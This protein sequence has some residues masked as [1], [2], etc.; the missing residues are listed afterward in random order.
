[1]DL[2]LCHIT[3]DFDALGAAIGLT[4]LMPG[5][6]VV[7]TGGAHPAVGDFLAFYRDEFPLIERRSV[8][9]QEIRNLAI[10]DTQKRDR[11]GKAAEWLDLPHLES[12]SVFDHHPQGNTDI[13][14]TMRQIEPVGATTTLI[15]E[16]IQAEGL[17]LTPA[18]ATVMALGIHVDTGSLTFPGTSQRDALALSW[19][20]GQKVQ[21][22]VVAQYV[23]PGLSL[24]LQELFK[25]ALERIDT[26]TVR[27]YQ[28]ASVLL[29]TEE[30]QPGLSTLAS[31]LRDIAETDALLLGAAYDG[32]KM[33]VI[34][35][36]QIPGVELNEL[37]QEFGGGGHP[38]AAALTLKAPYPA[39]TLAMLRDRLKHQV[40]RPLTARELMSSP[41]R[42]IRPETT[43]DEAQ[44]ILLRY[45]H[46]GL[47]V[48]DPEEGLVGM[49]SRRDIDLALHHG[50]S[51]APVKGYMA[52]QVKTVTPITLFPE[53]EALMVTY[54]IGRLPVL[55]EGKPV[56]IVTRTDVL[57]HL[58]RSQNHFDAG[59]SEEQSRI[60]L[61]LNLAKY[62][63]LPLWQILTQAA[64]AASARGWQLYVVGGSVRDLL[65]ARQYGN[66]SPELHDI[67]LV[68]D[69]FDLS[70]DTGAGVEL[71]K[72]LQ[73]I[74]PDSRLDVHGAFQTAALIW[75][76]HPTLGSL[77]LD[78]A[79]ARTE[80]YPYPAANPEVEASSI[81]QDLYRRD[82][83]INALA[84]R[85][86]PDR[87][88]EVLDFF[89]GAIDLKDRQI[90]VLH[91][92][93]LIEDP[94][95]IYRAVRFAVR[96]GFRIEAQ[97]EG[98]IRY[99]IESGVYQRSLSNNKKAPA[100]Q[101]RLRAELK[102]ILEAHYWEKAIKLLDSL[103]AL[104]CLHPSLKLNRKLWWQLHLLDRWLR[105][106]G[107]ETRRE[108]SK[109]T[110]F[111]ENL[112]HWLLRLEVLFLGIEPQER[113]LVAQNL[114]LPN[115]SIERLSNL[116]GY[117]A[118]IASKLP[119]LERVSEIVRLLRGYD[120]PTLILVGLNP[121]SRS[122][123]QIIWKYLTIWKQVR[124][125]LNGNDLKAL[126]YPSGALYKEILEDLLAATL[127][128]TVSD[129]L[130][131]AERDR[132]SATTYL[133]AKYPLS[134]EAVNSKI[135]SD[136][137]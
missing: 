121:D 76:K 54:D 35:R 84:V 125:P 74:Y 49:V 127:D 58:H 50:F 48:V 106:G 133:A 51:H 102:H 46:S 27:G 66:P 6:K 53:I 115:D 70:A 136:Q 41:V 130:G 63:P 42:T 31:R 4:R 43:I 103:D 104:R 119:E 134:T 9:P 17:E 110:A 129:S 32:E 10:V 8:H 13:P 91:P 135:R 83:T 71:A 61:T 59:E 14:A 69:G 29:E 80:F 1:M 85:L 26:E 82:F 79:T 3:V 123:R 98:Y 108:G 19:L 38:Q 92:N 137:T 65:L 111:A 99:A 68:V 56:G 75:R 25:V 93:S 114:Q 105:R 124:S 116:V 109:T 39:E 44:R 47:P 45:G 100:L 107:E 2:I 22:H 96:L 30:Y 81:R 64:D 60:D 33:T 126:G 28:V 57:R 132:E 40:P 77:W 55:A 89:G 97:T 23:D 78:I 21:L 52:R 112:V 88:G 18:E 16:K 67:D 73:K 37:F 94:T 7:L 62:L 87:A 128:G 120:I 131:C 113:G 5:S 34:G 90:R 12:I 20:M 11:L 117:Q 118:E 95:R 101:T 36:S 122:T 72:A 15:V 86:T 24:P